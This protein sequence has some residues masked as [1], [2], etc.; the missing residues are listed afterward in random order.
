MADQLTEILDLNRKMVANMDRVIG[1]LEVS[2]LVTARLAEC[3]ISLTDDE[4]VLE[5][6]RA[7]LQLGS[8]ALKG[9]RED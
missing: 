6:L 7:T 3:V 2:L 9:I 8:A 1:G 4:E 5:N